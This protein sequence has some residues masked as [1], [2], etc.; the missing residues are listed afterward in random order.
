MK[1]DREGEMEDG[2]EVNTERHDVFIE[3]QTSINYEDHRKEVFFFYKTMA[4][5][6]SRVLSRKWL[7]HC[8]RDRW[9]DG[10][11]NHLYLRSLGLPSVSICITPNLS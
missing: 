5:L 1:I 3:K 11:L 8:A 6:M 4:R 7:T 9:V 10:I 2:L